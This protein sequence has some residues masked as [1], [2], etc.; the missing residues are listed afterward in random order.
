MREIYSKTIAYLEQQLN[1]DIA[2]RFDYHDQPI[3]LVLP[4][5]VELNRVQ[6]K[7]LNAE[8]QGSNVIVAGRLVYSNNVKTSDHLIRMGYRIHPDFWQIYKGF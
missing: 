8:I 7:H 4:V 2:A 3:K 6:Q 5:G 1:R